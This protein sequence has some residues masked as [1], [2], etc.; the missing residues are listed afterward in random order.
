MMARWPR[1]YPG[2][3]LRKRVLER[4]AGP[5]AAVAHLRAIA[6]RFG[7]DREWR[8]SLGLLLHDLGAYE[9]ALA[10]LAGRT[11][12]ED[13]DDV[14][15]ARAAALTMLGRLD[16][17]GAFC[18]DWMAAAPDS[19]TPA[20][21]VASARIATAP[22]PGGAGVPAGEPGPV[23]IAQFWDA[24]EP[25][26]D[27]REV[28]DTWT[29]LHPAAVRVVFSQET[30]RDHLRDAFGGEAVAVFDQC[31]HAAMK[32]D[33][34]RVAW[35]LSRGGVWVDADERC[36]ASVA[37]F[38]AYAA[39]R[40]LAAPL[41]GE[42]PGYVH[43]L[44]MGA[45]RGSPILQM[46]F[47]AACGAVARGAREQRTLDIWQTTGPGLITRAAAAHL[48]ADPDAAAETTL[49]ALGRYA[50]FAATEVSLEYKRRRATN[51]HA[52]A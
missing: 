17:M 4:E 6:V 48:L 29:A 24:P 39:T 35:L 34:F 51:W 7:A 21:F 9:E 10:L 1:E 3:E 45:R 49:F 31:R 40:R 50:A 28:M 15:L 30:A 2:F 41:A 22:G 26:A 36:L 52:Q 8:R 13:L 23:A 5:A 38:L 12:A 27:V 18:R 20:G 43:N 32:A 25:P 42:R 37:P 47:D 19:T 16:E 14:R 33:L 46:A 11:A 44:F